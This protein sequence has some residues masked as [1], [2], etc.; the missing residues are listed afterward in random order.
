MKLHSTPRA[1]TRH[2]LALKAGKMLPRKLHPTWQPFL[3]TVL[4]NDDENTPRATDFE[5]LGVNFHGEAL[6]RKHG[7]ARNKLQEDQQQQ[8]QQRKVVSKNNKKKAKK[9]QQQQNQD[10]AAVRVR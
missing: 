6:Q 9:Q 3:A 8:Q 2:E 7:E 4:L 5:A 1:P 10:S